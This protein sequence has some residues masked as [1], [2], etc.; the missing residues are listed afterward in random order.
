VR[1][2]AKAVRDA[3]KYLMLNYFIFP[4]VTDTMAELDAL[5]EWIE[6]DRIDMVQLRNLNI[7]PEMYLDHVT[8]A[9]HVVEPMGLMPWLTELRRRFPALR[10]G[11]F[12]PPRRVMLAPAPQLVAV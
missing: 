7:D 5:S 9:G 8:R 6:S 11:Y 2:S 4:G 10:F 1:A 3:G 12:N